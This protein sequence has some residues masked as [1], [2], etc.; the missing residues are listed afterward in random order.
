MTRPPEA[1]LA[2]SRARLGA[3]SDVAA[4]G[5]AAGAVGVGLLAT[6]APVVALGLTAML[7]LAA[8]MMADLAVALCVFTV[9]TFFET[10]P[11]FGALPV[12]ASKLAGA[13]L[14]ASWI[15]VLAVRRREQESFLTAHA[16]LTWLLLAFLAWVFAS[17]A[18]AQDSGAAASSLSRYAPNLLLVPIVFTALRDRRAVVAVAVA[19]VAAAAV[20]AG[21]GIL[22]PPAAGVV[23]EPVRIAGTVGDANEL[24]AVLVAAIPL[25]GALA[26]MA[27]G[28]P[29]LRALALA[30]AVCCGVGTLLTVSR[31]GL[32]ALAGM[33][34]AAVVLAGARRRVAATSIAIVV[35]LG[36]ILYFAA[37]AS[38]A[39][40]ERVLNPGSGTGRADLWKI[41]LRMTSAR[42]VLGVG[43]GNFPVTSVH[44]LLRPGAIKRDDL[45]IG[46]PQPAHSIFLGVLAELG[47]VGLALFGAIVLTCMGAALAAARLFARAR[48][49]PMELLARSALVALVG[50]LVAS[51]FLSDQYGQQLWLL[52]GLG[53]GLLRVARH[54]LEGDAA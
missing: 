23:S 46:K 24:A 51:V 49:G 52:L 38:P 14:I 5:L 40:R 29:G 2:P 54:E 19:F 3:R 36:A 35:V 18:W 27:R 17:L 12:S 21:Y 15:A 41:A 48:D 10:L 16:G 47:A 53:P 11:A 43:A 8:L 25:A 31:G 7:V 26:A 44:Y 6:A 33:A 13:G 32:V 22:E 9:V 39:A 42:P 4:A 28:R 30:A 20:A 1:V 50:L 34:I 45:V 37:F